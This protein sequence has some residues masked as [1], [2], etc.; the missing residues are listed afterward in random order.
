MLDIAGDFEHRL[1]VV[2]FILVAHRDRSYLSLHVNLKPS[3]VL[4]NHFRFDTSEL[5][6]KN[7]SFFLAKLGRGRSC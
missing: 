5:F 6:R 2:N 1:K 3:Y 4:L 7:A